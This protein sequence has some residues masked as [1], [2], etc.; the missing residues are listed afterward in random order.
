M[1]LAEFVRWAGY[2]NGIVDA[3]LLVQLLRYRLA[4]KYCWLFCYFL[5]DAVQPLLTISLSPYSI[6]YGYIYFGGQAVKALLGVA[7]VIK[8][9]KQALLRYPALAR[10]GRQIAIYMLLAATAV[11]VVGLLLEPPPPRRQLL[12]L[13]W[14]LAIEGAVDSMVLLFLAAA[15]LFLL[16]FPVKVRRNVAICLGAFA[17]Y[18]FHRWAG[19]LLVNLYPKSSDAVNAV[20]LVLSFACVAL[21]TLAVRPEGEIVITVTGHHWN[22]AETEH[23]LGQ[24]DAI[25]TRLERMAR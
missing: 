22:P 2:L 11:A 23:L 6:W 12:L 16:W 24:L 1:T 17:F 21:W 18:L 4:R 13:H 20:L 15:V 7:L 10:F 5:A 19:L 9:W 3:A 14:L 8:L 25:N